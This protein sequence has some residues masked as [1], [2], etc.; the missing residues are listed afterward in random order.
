MAWAYGKELRERSLHPIVHAFPSAVMRDAWL[1]G[2]RRNRK[3]RS[4]CNEVTANEARKLCEEARGRRSGPVVH[5][6]IA[7]CR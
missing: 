1:A 3:I 2:M 4:L 6:M 5:R 7:E